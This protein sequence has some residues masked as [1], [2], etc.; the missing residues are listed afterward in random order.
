MTE[1]DVVVGLLS[2]R[3]TPRDT[4]AFDVR[5]FQD[6]TMQR[7]FFAVETLLMYGYTPSTRRILVGFD[8]LNWDPVGIPEL[9]DRL[10]E[11]G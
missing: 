8:A 10:R 6:R 2:G 9:V 1:R 4:R 5:R 11:E 7:L 3:L